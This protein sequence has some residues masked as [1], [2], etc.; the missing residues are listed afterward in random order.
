MTLLA[1]T[2]LVD[3][4]NANG[5]SPAQ[6]CVACPAGTYS[7]VVGGANATGCT[8]CPAGTAWAG[9]GADS[10]LFCR[11]C[12]SGE[13]AG[14]GQ[15]TCGKCEIYQSSDKTNTGCE[16]DTIAQGIIVGFMCAIFAGVVAGCC[17]MFKPGSRG[18][19]G[20]MKH[21]KVGPLR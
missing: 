16:L 5:T 9:T 13:Y 4:T 10:E 21:A 14:L 2:Y 20:I 11:G 17:I 7:E 15:A 8:S 3:D 19:S 18:I 6:I 1:G 12:N